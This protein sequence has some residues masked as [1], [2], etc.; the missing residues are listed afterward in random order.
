MTAPARQ[1]FPDVILKPAWRVLR[2][3]TGVIYLAVVAALIFAERD[4]ASLP[5]TFLC[6]ALLASLASALTRRPKFSIGLA[7]ALLS[8]SAAV[9]IVK[10]KYLGFNAHI[11]DL[12]FYFAKADTFAYLADELRWGAMTVV[13][14]LIALGALVVRL[15]RRDTISPAPRLAGAGLAA[16]AAAA[17]PF[18][19][20][21]GADD[22]AYHVPARHFVSS[23]FVSLFDLP[24]L[25]RP[26]PLAQ[27]LTQLNDP[28]APFPEGALCRPGE[29]APDI[30]LVLSESAVFPGKVPGWK[31]DPSITDY[32][33]SYDGAVHAARVE[34]FGGGTWISHTSALTGLSMADFGWIR[35]YVTMLLRG[36]VRHSLP[37][38]LAACGYKT[39][40]ISPSSFNFVNEGPMLK[41][42]GIEDYLDRKTLNAGKHEPDS[43]YFARALD[44][45]RKHL[46]N[47][48]RPLFMYIATM[49]AHMPYF[50]RFEPARKAQGEPFGNDPESDEYLRRE[51]FAQEDY[52]AFVDAL[53]RARG[54]RLALVAEFGDHHPYVTRPYFEARGFSDPSKNDFSSPLFET[55]YSVTPLG[56]SPSVALPRFAL[57]IAY[58]GVTL[59]ESAGLPL[60]PAYEAQR[61]L[62]DHCLGAFHNCADRAAVDRYL[63]RMVRS[64]R[65]LES[66]GVAT[67]AEPTTAAN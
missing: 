66:E 37:L 26:D 54:A 47:D 21:P 44:Y 45:Y 34:A 32:F 14:A 53:A 41:S 15:Y 1:T 3:P 29:K 4:A 46:K 10:H 9:S 22:I 5:F 30:F 55:F 51:T 40:M 39:A 6:W 2:S 63:S 24:R 13:A 58:L 49:A 7:L 59:L 35:P 60:G 27:R 28:A 64:G 23:W 57:D 61:A 16:L 48:G 65:L 43:F 12:R 20:P 17:L 56:F 36:R 31:F 33:R 62:R 25:S 18:A 8:L 42:L 19:L 11:F 52:R 38:A 50:D 67:R